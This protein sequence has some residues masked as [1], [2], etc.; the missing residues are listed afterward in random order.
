M[1]EFKV[2]D[3]VTITDLNTIAQITS[4]SEDGTQFTL[5]YQDAGGADQTEVRT[6]DQLA[7]VGAEDVKTGDEADEESSDAEKSDDGEGSEGEGD[8][9]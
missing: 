3:K 8:G 4:I 6:A 9:E 1:N 5:T 2:G 7:P